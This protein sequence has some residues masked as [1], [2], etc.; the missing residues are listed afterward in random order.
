MCGVPRNLVTL[1]HAVSHQE[2]AEHRRIMDEVAELLSPRHRVFVVTGAG[3]SAESGLPTYRGTGG[4]YVSGRTEQ[5]MTIEELLSGQTFRWQPELTWRYLGEIGRAGAGKTC[6]PG[7]R[8]L[9]ALEPRFADFCILTQNIDG[10][11]TAAGSRN[12][13]EI[14]GNLHHLRCESCGLEKTVDCFT[15]IEI[16]PACDQCQQP[17][18]PGVVLFGEMLP[19][20]ALQHL[21]RQ[22]AAGFDVVLSIGTSSNFPYIAEPVVRAARAGLPT[23]EINPEETSVSALCSHRLDLPASL[24][25]SGIRQRLE[26]RPDWPRIAGQAWETGRNR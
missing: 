11:H 9:A 21:E 18:R 12:V 2:T 16:P 3:M 6:N 1:V 26:C 17:L 7:H 5:G 8:V 4:L 24:A 19:T 13:I 14:H 10:F 15:R 22:W 20:G 25:L 23:I